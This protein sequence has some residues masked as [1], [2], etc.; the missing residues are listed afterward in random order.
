MTENRFVGNISQEELDARGK[1]KLHHYVPVWWQMGF[2]DGQGLL[3]TAD[4]NRG[5]PRRVSPKVL[6]A[7][8]RLYQVRDAD[9]S[10]RPPRVMLDAEDA[11]CE[12]D[13]VFVST[14]R[15]VLERT[16][17]AAAAG[18]TTVEVD[19]G[20]RRNLW[21]FLI[22]QFLRKL[23]KCT[24]KY[25]EAGEPKHIVRAAELRAVLGLYDEPDPRTTSILDSCCLEMAIAPSGG[26]LVLG[27]DP[28]CGTVHNYYNNKTRP[29][30]G[31]GVVGVPLDRQTF[32]LWRRGRRS[33]DTVS[34]SRLTTQGLKDVNRTVLEQSERIAGPDK[35]VIH[36][37]LKAHRARRRIAHP[38]RRS[39]ADAQSVP[40]RNAPVR[41]KHWIPG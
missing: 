8:N 11:F 35:H 7:K 26:T 36:A 33:R 29:Q 10:N 41:T 19:S 16:A 13:R 38:R 39:T 6:F 28:V 32:V 34:V 17:T 24:S 30:E 1:R 3:W 25:I 14:V 40:R 20:A 21:Q 4:K 31:H 2:T 37:L 18:H 15:S 9:S 22:M 23:G 27:T 5:E 12:A